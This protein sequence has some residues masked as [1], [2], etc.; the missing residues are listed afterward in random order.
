MQEIHRREQYF[1]DEP[2][3]AHLAKFISGFERPVLLCTPMLGRYLNERGV[4]AQVLDVDHRFADLPGFRHWN[5]HNPEWLGYRP[6]LI[7]CDPPFHTVKLDRLF[8]AVRVLA[9][10]DVTVPLAVSWLKRR[11][12]ALLGTFAPFGLGPTDYRPGYVTVSEQTDIRF[13]GSQGIK[14]EEGKR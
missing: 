13:Y 7:L 9:G 6:G 2:T 3:L 11:E 1:F 8:R 12:R 4:F 5:I 10:F 14:L